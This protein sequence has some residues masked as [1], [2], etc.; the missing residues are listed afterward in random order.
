MDTRATRS[1]IGQLADDLAWLEQ[2]CRQEADQAY[3]AWRLRLAWVV[4]C[5]I[6]G[7]AAYRPRS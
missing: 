1:L 7:R 4:V 3:A 6:A 5:A 2:Y